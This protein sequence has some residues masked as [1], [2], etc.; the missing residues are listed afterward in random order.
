MG[1]QK[2]KTATESPVK[3]L[4]CTFF[5]LLKKMLTK[6]I[7]LSCRQ[8]VEVILPDS[9]RLCNWDYSSRLMIRKK[10]K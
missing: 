5:L 8:K 7:S 3:G 9:E 2:Y 1:A 6:I 10:Y 4:Y